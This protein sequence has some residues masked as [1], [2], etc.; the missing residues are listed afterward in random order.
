MSQLRS[1]GL[2]ANYVGGTKRARRQAGRWPR[3]TEEEMRGQ[4]G[5]EDLLRQ[6]REEKEN[7]STSQQRSL[8][9][10]GRVT[11]LMVTGQCL[12]RGGHD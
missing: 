10:G 12:A 1:P 8:W 2:P 7:V 6:P 4:W 5:Q 9:E 3:F 11:S